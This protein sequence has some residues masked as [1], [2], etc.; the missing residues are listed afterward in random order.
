MYRQSDLQFLQDVFGRDSSDMAIVYGMRNLGLSEII[1]D[2]IKDKECLY[3]RAGAFSIDMQRRIFIQEFHD[4]TKFPIFSNDDYEKILSSYIN[5]DS[6]KKKLVVFDDFQY[7]L[8][9]DKTFINFLSSLLFRQGNKGRAMF[10]LVSDDVR[11]VEND[12]IR[13]IGK[14]SSEISGVIKLREFTA[15]EFF[16]CFPEMPLSEAIGIYSFIG[17]KS[18]YYNELSK[19][20]KTR[21]VIIDHLGMWDS[22]N[23]DPGIMLPKDIREPLLYNTVL[24]NMS[25]EAVKLA[26]LHERTGCDTAKLSVYLKALM[27]Y[28][29]V[30][31][32]TSAKVGNPANTQ[33]GMYRIKEPLTKFYYRFVLPHISSLSVLGPERFYRRFVENELNSFIGEG[34]PLICM[35]HIMWLSDNKRLNFKVSSVEE[36][37]DKAG[38]IDFVVIAAGGSVIACKCSYSAPHMNYRAYEMVAG[39]VR[40]NKINCDNIWL[41]ATGG[42]DQKLSITETVTPG[43]KLI[44]GRDQKL[45]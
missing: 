11:W 27:E 8:R 39:T 12:M 23:H 10:V 18:G 5:D 19:D 32:V 1:S 17:G 25:D 13:M 41:F 20:S 21:Q 26:D 43:V 38:A 36:Y 29:I 42:F 14:K 7:L 6:G 35:E 30:E 37:H 34:Y 33:K 15:T 31:K 16:S 9:Q 24:L 28:G 45:R 40:K 44:E 3:Y 22:K 2:F 4:Q